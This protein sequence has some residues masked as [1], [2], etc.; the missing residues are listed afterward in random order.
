M[1]ERFILPVLS[2]AVGLS[3]A[4]SPWDALADSR[5]LPA[6]LSSAIPCNDLTGNW[7]FIPIPLPERNVTHIMVSRAKDR[8]FV[9]TPGGVASYDGIIARAPQFVS[10]E[11]QQPIY[12]NSMV[13]GADGA[14]IVGTI[15][16]SLW[17]WNGDE[18]VALYG[19]C[20]RG[21][22]G[23]PRGEWA[24]ARSED[25]SIYVAS[26][27]FAPRQTDALAALKAVVTEPLVPVQASASFLGFAGEELVATTNS[28][29]IHL[30]DRSSGKSMRR[31]DLA[32]PSGAFVRNVSYARGL[33]LVGTDKGCIGVELT[34]KTAPVAIADGNCSSVYMQR[35]GTFWLSTDLLYRHDR[36]G[37]M[38]WSPERSGPLT[39][40]SVVEDSLSNIWIGSSLG[41]WRYFDVS[42]DR[43]FGGRV[44]SMAPD[45]NGGLAVGLENGEVW[46]L[47]R[48][49][50]A[51][52]LEL[53][54]ATELPPSPYYRGALLANDPAGKLWV[55]SGAGLFTVSGAKAERIADYPVPGSDRVGAPS[56]LAVSSTGKACVGLVWS[57][58]VLCL[59]DGA[60]KKSAEVTGQ[61]GGSAVGAVAF[62]NAGSLLAVGVQ[63][64]TT[65]AD[66]PK[67]FGPFSPTPFGKNHLFGAIAFTPN[68]D[69][70]DVV[71]S[72]GWGGTVFLRR[73][74]KEYSDVGHGGADVQ[75]QPYIIRQLASHPTLGLL[76][77]GDSGLFR[78]EGTPMQGG[79][80][81][82]RDIDPRLA[83]PIAGVVPS[84]DRAFWVAS[85]SRV[86]LIDLP[87]AAPK[88]RVGRS[89]SAATININA[90]TYHLA[91]PGLVGVPSAKTTTLAY[92]PPIANAARRIDGPDNRLDLSNLDD[93][94][95][96]RLT[97]TVT[98][99]FL[100][101][102]PP[103]SS[104]FSVRLPFYRNPYELVIA[105]LAV[106]GLLGLLLTRRGP[107]GFVLRRIGGLRWSTEKSDP[108]FAVEVTSVGPDM[109]RYELEAPSA[110]TPVQLEVDVPSAQ[111]D[112]MPK[113][114]LPHL[115]RIA[116]GHVR[117]A[118]DDFESAVGRASRVLGEVA[119]PESLRFVTSQF[120]HGTMSLD[121]SK[122]LLW[123]PLELADDGGGEL[124]QLRYAIGRTVSADILAEA[125][126]PR[127]PR[128]KVAVF[129]PHVDA[130]DISLPHIKA[131]AQAVAAA[132][133]SWGAE[134]TLVR[135]DAT[136]AEVID[137]LCNAHLFHYA[138]HAEFV[139]DTAGQ[140]YL[141]IR[142][143]RIMAEEIANALKS[144]P[145]SLMLAFINGCGTS[146]EA[147]WERSAEVYGFASAFVNNAAYFIGAQ[148]PIGDEFAASFAS[149]F[150]T[151]LFPPAYD[152]WWRLVRRDRLHGVPFAEALRL[153][154][155]H[156]REMGPD[157][158][159][160]WSSYVFYGDPTRRLVLQ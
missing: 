88:V 16:D 24:L 71:A 83:L 123:L 56:S 152:L 95:T 19:A 14:V 50:E 53:P 124:V 6:P 3:L 85:D 45:P 149:E 92:D 35:D 57:T 18:I 34:D 145:H 20:P 86:T 117:P 66:E 150:Y 81:S 13:E 93:R 63:S 7:Q 107:T 79:W 148:W 129:A 106:V 115:L 109:V 90:V 36:N 111:L 62:D 25:G 140:S 126:P 67:E 96:Y 116:E 22:G 47:S 133:R 151:R 159:Q 128:L 157:A 68:V 154:R 160:T 28:G 58:A 113:E 12:V 59:S 89:P 17:R 48:A 40:G 97:A 29:S 41:L 75:E 127:S 60:W 135:A 102:G 9:G 139:P 76:A 158:T 146:R 38:R 78:W 39:A 10:D 11:A 118:Q 121:L 54:A 91:I 104:G 143:D 21:S 105:V 131:E 138:G 147:S 43:K 69:G 114:V 2:I 130:S 120:D 80:K 136:K 42:R 119:L 153:A 30:I 65:A 101:V 44:S 84:T 26:S 15:N 132:A 61:V 72:G 100:N 55:L 27:S 33:I 8:V 46:Q 82:L 1:A 99:G 70:A 125:D 98:D 32:L 103:E 141:P 134:V 122:S 94:T 37:W 31:I 142:E 137:A 23:C 51:T 87:T 4:F 155:R 52:Q 110:L 112:G 5:T 156:L 73:N 49:L 64:I 74:G 144:K 108:R 77:G